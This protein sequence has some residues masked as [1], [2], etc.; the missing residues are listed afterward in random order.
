MSAIITAYSFLAVSLVN[1]GVVL[2]V[3]RA[4]NANALS[5]LILLI[6]YAHYRIGLIAP[7]AIAVAEK[8]RYSDWM[9]TCPLLVYELAYLR[10]LKPF[11]KDAVKVAAASAASIAMVSAGWQAWKQTG[12]MRVFWWGIGSVFLGIIF[13]LLLSK[14]E[15]EEKERSLVWVSDVFLWLWIPYG[16][17]FWLPSAI[18]HVA[19]NVLD[20]L[21]KSVLGLA[22]AYT[23]S[24]VHAI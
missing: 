21:S 2:K 12:R 14:P 5:I 13:C 6:A 18:R 17:V 15:A 11:G 1:A 4:R 19:F 3:P 22:I 20:I 16:I 10:G 23:T 24:T 8:F 7:G 9:I